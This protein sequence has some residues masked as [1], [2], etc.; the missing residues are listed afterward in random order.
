MAYDGPSIFLAPYGNNAALEN[1][2]RTVLNGVSSNAVTEHTDRTLS[3]DIVRLWGT[4]ESVEG[5][6]KGIN[7]GDYL[8]FYRDGTYTHATEVLATEK[9]AELGKATWSNYEEDK[10]WLCIIYLGE[11]VEINAD[12]SMVHDLAGYDI[13]YPM[14][15]S[16]LNEMGIGGIRGKYGSVEA[17]AAAEPD[18]PK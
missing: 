14:G 6:W 2:R 4:K 10:P 12:S 9:N 3:G 16:P 15:F 7:S 1:F 8:I 5:S 13:D 18:T 17:F 11:P